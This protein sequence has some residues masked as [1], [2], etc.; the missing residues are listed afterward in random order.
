M[1]ADP[2]HDLTRAE[3]SSIHDEGGALG[4]EAAAHFAGCAECAE[5]AVALGHIDVLLARGQFDRAPDLSREVMRRTRSRT[6]WWAVAAAAAVGIVTGALIGGLGTSVER[7]RAGDLADLFA[8]AEPVVEALGAELLIVERGWHPEVP[9]RVYVGTLGYDAPESLAISLVDTTRY[10][11]P[12]WMPNDLL[13]QAADGDYLAVASSRCPVAALPGC[14]EPPVTTALTGRRPFAEGLAVGQ[15]VV[16]PGRILTRWGG[17]EVV[18]APTLGGR[19][20]IQIETTVAGSDLVRAVTERGA[21]R[22]LHPTDRVLMWLDEATL[23]PLRVEVFAAASPERELWG[24]R[25][26]YRD[27]SEEPIFIIELD[28]GADPA[29]IAPDLPDSALS[30]GFLDGEAEVPEPEL[31]SELSPHRFGRW[32]LPDGAEVRVGS[33]SDGRAWLR[34]EVTEGWEEPRLFGIAGPFAERIELGGGSVGY[35]SP[36]G[37]SIALHAEDIDVLITGSLQLERLIDAAASLPVVGVDIPSDWD[38]AA[39]VEGARLPE[40]VLVPLVEGWSVLGLTDE[41]GVTLLLTG[42]G[43]R[44]V[45]VTQRPGDR[46]EP[47]DGPDFYAVEVDGITARFDASAQLLEWVDDGLV[48]T[49]RSETVGLGDLLALATAMRR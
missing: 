18:G 2:L 25:R 8:A 12:E 33:W 11:G 39:V 37:S 47:P 21:W 9:E 19:P 36:D 16:G 34:V 48:V 42:A 29:E 4:E 49:M 5:F 3:L 20:T 13:L 26:G 44:A 24:L 43:R 14:Q 31:D 27:V 32:F 10:P 35:L 1:P 38:Q 46:L 22:E 45:I 7:V 40:D 23:V 28:P 30:A 6:R 17:V 41:Q 15:G